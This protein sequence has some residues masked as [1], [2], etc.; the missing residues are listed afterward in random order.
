M[1]RDGSDSEPTNKKRKTASVV[2][3][4]PTTE[5]KVMVDSVPDN[6]M[7]M[8]DM[9]EWPFEPFCDLLMNDLFN[10]SWEKRHGAATGLREV[11]KLHG[12]GAGK[13]VTMS[14]QQVTFSLIIKH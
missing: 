3:E 11:L 4:Q 6:T 8:E 14:K 2:V 12:K 7:N 5:N 1:S 10:T 9:V 13:T